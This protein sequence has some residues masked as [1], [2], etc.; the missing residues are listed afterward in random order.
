M[1]LLLCQEELAEMVLPENA[2]G[3]PTPLMF[4]QKTKHL[5]SF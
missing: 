2:P 3:F 1:A 5:E 4:S